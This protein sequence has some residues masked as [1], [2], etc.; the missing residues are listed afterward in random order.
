MAEQPTITSRAPKYRRAG[1]GCRIARQVRKIEVT[2]VVQER[3]A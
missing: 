3:L 2:E 1:L